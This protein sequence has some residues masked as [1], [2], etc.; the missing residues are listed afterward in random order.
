MMSLCTIMAHH[1]PHFAAT[2]PTTR[3]TTLSNLTHTL[4][5][6]NTSNSE[7]SA[8]LTDITLQNKCS[9]ALS[10]SIQLHSP[11]YLS[12]QPSTQPA[13][14]HITIDPE[15]IASTGGLYLPT[16]QHFQYNLSL[17]SNSH[18]SFPVV[19]LCDSALLYVAASQQEPCPIFQFLS[20][21]L[22]FSRK[23]SLSANIFSKRRHKW[24]ELCGTSPPI[25]TN[26]LKLLNFSRILRVAA[27]V[28]CIQRLIF[29]SELKYLSLQLRILF[30]THPHH[31][32]CSFKHAAAL[33]LEDSPHLYTSS[34]L[35][36]NI[37]AFHKYLFS[38]ISGSA[39]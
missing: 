32:P 7:S 17:L 35:S 3:S 13:F 31:V 38:F 21:L 9:S 12:C 19:A 26:C 1:I 30:R 25:S 18:S 23:P 29:S 36:I 37:S 24:I 4:A 5:S 34:N 20:L 28:F 27:L 6:Q 11:K 14:P 39:S 16:L 15:A 22:L 8:W 33:P 2:I 10:A